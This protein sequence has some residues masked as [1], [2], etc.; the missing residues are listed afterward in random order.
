M[1]PARTLVTLLA[2]WLTLGGSVAP[3]A[4][5]RAGGLSRIRGIPGRHYPGEYP[6]IS[7]DAAGRSS[8]VARA[9]D[10]SKSPGEDLQGLK[11]TK[12]EVEALEDWRA[13]AAGKLFDIALVS[14]AVQKF[15]KSRRLY[16]TG[17]ERT[18]EVRNKVKKMLDFRDQFKEE[19][20][21][22]V[23]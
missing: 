19:L 2:A 23:W 12:E 16:P 17:P 21:E 13:D 8:M 22:E 1:A 14:L 10:G 11:V 7:G 20:G 15:I 4:R 6:R 5:T 18:Y 9:E 3:R